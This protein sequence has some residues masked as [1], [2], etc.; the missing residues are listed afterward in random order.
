M[1]Y[2]V[3]FSYAEGIRVRKLSIDQSYL[4]GIETGKIHSFTKNKSFGITAQNYDIF[5]Q[6]ESVLSIVKP[7]LIHH[8]EEY[9]Y[10]LQLKEE[11]LNVFADSDKNEIATGICHGDLQAENFHISADDQFTFFDFDFFGTGCLAYDIGV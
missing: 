2:E 7:I 11:F 5:F 9:N 3:L 10:L 4:L 1:R 6:F 8:Q